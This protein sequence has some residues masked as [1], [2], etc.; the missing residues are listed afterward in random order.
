MRWMLRSAVLLFVS[1]TLAV[2]GPPTSPSSAQTVPSLTVMPDTGLTGGDVVP[3]TGTGFAPNSGVYFCERDQAG[4][5]DQTSCGNGG[6]IPPT[7]T[8]DGNGAFSVPV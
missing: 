3:L 1:G 4:P 8:A 5:F 2:A 6:N 7:V